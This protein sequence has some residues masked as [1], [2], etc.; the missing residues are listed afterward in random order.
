MPQRAPEFEMSKTSRD[1]KKSFDGK[2]R[3]KLQAIALEM[4]G[5]FL[6]GVLEDDDTYT[7]AFDDFGSTFFDRWRVRFTEQ[8]V[9]AQSE[10]VALAASML[11]A[12][13]AHEPTIRSLCLEAGRS[14]VI[15]ISESDVDRNELLSQA[16]TRLVG[17][18]L[19]E[20]ERSFLHIEPNYLI[21]PNGF[22][23]P[24]RIGRVTSMRTEEANTETPLAK[25]PKLK[26]VP[27]DYPNITM[28]KGH[29]SVGMPRMVWIVDVPATRENLAEEAKW[30]IDVAVSFI[31]LSS[32]GW[33]ARFPATGQVEPHP[34]RPTLLRPP[35][36]SLEGSA[37]HAGGFRASPVY[38][39]DPAIYAELTDEQNL[40][41]A[42]VLFDPP[43][44]SLALRVSQGLGWMTRGRQVS[45]RAERLLAFFTALEA[46]LSSDDKTAP[47]TQTISR[48]VSVIYSQDIKNRL[49]I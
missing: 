27:G 41:R 9:K 14:T 30:L 16:A 12:R 47:I 2:Q 29:M 33:S 10:F 24:I 5:C 13:N 21:A 39:V 3:A 8:F 4:L 49:I 17:T 6:D 32:S 18:V 46:L 42:E 37:A 44:N 22:D 38:D 20:L 1:R 48:F 11:K 25:N 7:H 40:R 43:R 28:S 31:R 15:E 36:V 23:G 26:L 45:D 19:A 34:T 35:H